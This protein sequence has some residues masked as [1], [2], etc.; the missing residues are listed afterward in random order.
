M[1]G[2]I[3][4]VAKGA[5]RSSPWMHMV[6]HGI[7]AKIIVPHS[8]LARVAAKSKVGS[9]TAANVKKGWHMIAFSRNGSEVVPQSSA[10]P[11]NPT[12]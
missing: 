5:A 3:F 11:V 9:G 7:L 6:F 4:F 2:S 12:T 1:G 10:S 8:P